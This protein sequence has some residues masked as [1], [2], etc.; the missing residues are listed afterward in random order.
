MISY[1][2]SFLIFCKMP[3]TYDNFHIIRKSF[4][5][6]FKNSHFCV[7]CVLLF[8]LS[9]CN[10]FLNFRFILLLCY[11]QFQYFSTCLSFFLS[12]LTHFSVAFPTRSL[13]LSLSLILLFDLRIFLDMP[14]FVMYPLNENTSSE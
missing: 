8:G 14:C 11:Q 6:Y 4:Y 13:F 1:L 7:A 9:V 2:N 5:K 3:V 10:F 12:V